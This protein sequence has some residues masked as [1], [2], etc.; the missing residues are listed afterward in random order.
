MSLSQKLRSHHIH[1]AFIRARNLFLDL[2]GLVRNNAHGLGVAQLSNEG[3]LLLRNFDDCHEGRESKENVLREWEASEQIAQ[4]S[5]FLDVPEKEESEEGAG[6]RGPAQD[7]LEGYHLVDSIVEQLVRLQVHGRVHGDLRVYYVCNE[8]L[9]D[10]AAGVDQ[11]LLEVD[12]VEEEHVEACG[13]DGWHVC[14]PVP[15]NDVQVS[16][17]NEL[18]KQHHAATFALYSDGLGITLNFVPDE[19]FVAK[20]LVENYVSNGV[21]IGEADEE[22]PRKDLAVEVLLK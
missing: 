20:E 14:E 1:K 10:L 3:L 11:A 6:A 8:V 12:E 18:V 13:H 9:Y 21:G 5:S 17:L 16:V 22:S 4:A 15:D 2:V 19:E 7:A